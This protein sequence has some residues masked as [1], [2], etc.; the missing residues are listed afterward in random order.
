MKRMDHAAYKRRI[1]KLS[2]DA[3]AFTVRDAREAIAAMPDG[4]N[5]S[6]YLDEIAYA[7]EEIVRRAK[8]HT[9]KKANAR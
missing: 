5:I 3:L 8:K 4:E 7:S 2:D 9:K 1:R 6:Y